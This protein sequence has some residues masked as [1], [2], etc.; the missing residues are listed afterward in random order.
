MTDQ[1]SSPGE[2]FQQALLAIQ[3]GDVQGWLSLCTDDVIFEFPFAP[4]GRP[5]KVEG[6]EALGRYLA[7]IPSRIQFDGLSNLEIHQTLNPEVAIVEMTA[8]GMVRDTGEPYERSYVVV[9]T[10]R[11][12]KIAR[13]RDYW[14]PLEALG[15]PEEG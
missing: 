14:N 3:S 11:E 2:V 4:P 10:V 7:G 6:K 15:A 9:L 13:Y 8:T 1:T 5:S 12:G